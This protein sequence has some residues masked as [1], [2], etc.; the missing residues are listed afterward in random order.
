MRKTRNTEFGIAAGVLALSIFTASAPAK[1]GDGGTWP[2]PTFYTVVARPGDSLAKLAARY[3]VPVADIARMNGLKPRG[4]LAAGEILR[5]P[6]GSSTT[7]EAVLAEALDR[8]APNYAPP[9][10][11]FGTPGYARAHETQAVQE[12]SPQAGAA[13]LDRSV[14][15]ASERFAW[16]VRGAGDIVL[17]ARLGRRTQ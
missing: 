3:D 14:A 17:W 11:S 4:A 5:I 9:P 7:R 15:A 8:D 6:G 16:P 12:E 1:T 13:A 10:K 2:H